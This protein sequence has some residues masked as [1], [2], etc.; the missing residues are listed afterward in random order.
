MKFRSFIPSVVG[1]ALALGLGLAPAA[2]AAPAGTQPAAESAPATVRVPTDAI[3]DALRNAL[4]TRTSARKLD[5]HLSNPRMQI[6]APAT[7]SGAVQVGDVSYDERSGRFTA[8]L[9][10]PGGDAAAQ[11]VAVTGRA[12]PIVQIPVLRRPVPAGEIIASG[13]IDWQDVPAPRA[14][15]SVVTDAAA[16]V[17]QAARRPLAAAQPLRAGDVQKPV[18]VQKGTL[19][20]MVVEAPGMVLTAIGRA[21]QDGG[22]GDTI[23]LT[24]PQSKR[25]VQG[26]VTGP[27]AVSIENRHQIVG[28]L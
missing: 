3:E 14:N 11:G 28:A 24:N 9:S 26:V 1:S 7:W 4:M 25:T 22:M 23:E 10:V 5:L 20:S 13:D 18:V 15:A 2:G 12:D 17:G 27:G 19:V 16:L 21:A 8:T 6:A